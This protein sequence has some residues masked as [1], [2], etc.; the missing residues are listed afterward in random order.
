MELGT[1]WSLSAVICEN[2][3]QVSMQDHHSSTHGW[4]AEPGI[5]RCIRCTSFRRRN[6]QARGLRVQPKPRDKSPEDMSE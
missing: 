1:G 2:H 5:C 4:N 6:S 3:V